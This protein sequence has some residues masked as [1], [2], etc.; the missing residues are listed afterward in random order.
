[1]AQIFKDTDVLVIGGGLGGCWAAIKARD[2]APRVL[3]VDKAVVSRS[4]CSPWAYYFLAPIPE[5]DLSLWKREIVEG[6]DYFGDQDWIDALL[7]ENNRR[8]QDMESWGV[9]FERDGKGNLIIKKGR[10]HRSTGFITSDARTR[11]DALKRK[12]REAGVEIIE[13]VMIT[14]LLTSDGLLP[15]KGSVIGANG[16][17]TRTGDKVLI[18]SR[19][20]I[21]A[22]GPIYQ[23]TYLGT[24]LSG[25]GIA[26][27]FRTGAELMSMEFCIHPVCY[28]STGKQLLGTLNILFQS[29]NIKILNSKGE[30]FMEKYDPMLKEKVGWSLL[31]QALAKETLEGRG[32]AVLD[33][34]EVKDEDLAFF[35]RMHPGRMAPFIEAGID[36]KKDKLIVV[37]QVKVSS[38]SGDGGIRID[39]QGRTNIQGLYGA[40]SACKNQIQGTDAVGGMNLAF[41]CISGY[42][43]GER[44]AYDSLKTRDLPL[45]DKQIENLKREAFSPLQLGKGP[46]PDSL[47]QKIADITEPAMASIIKSKGGIEK[48]IASLEGLEK[49]ELKAVRARDF[50]EL[51]KANEA[52]NLALL[53]KLAFRSALEREESRHFHYRQDYPF[54]DDINWLKWVFVRQDASGE[55]KLRTEPV[56]LERYGIR[57]SQRRIVPNP[58]KFDVPGSE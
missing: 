17:H 7:E 45:Q 21:I 10:G 6:G 49:E 47:F 44:A 56:P 5:R 33:M 2:I 9:P 35:A 53:S 27:A 39:L 58:L 3:L 24:N 50:H 42:R 52:K 19:S 40:G 43:A 30:R 14:D 13:R 51:A 22:A 55:I 32:P 23:G 31:A 26:M 38:G 8:L 12:A 54:R 15:T 16:F 57:P 1:M 36:L 11:M 37:A 34:S 29:L 18:K 41:C 28:S 46:L 25:D 4:G 20:T 48:T